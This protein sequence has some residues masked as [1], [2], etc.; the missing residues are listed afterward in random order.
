VTDLD[1]SRL[2]DLLRRRATHR[3]LDLSLAGRSMG[4]RWERAERVLVAPEARPSRGEVWMFV[5]ANGRIVAHRCRR[6][7]EPARFRGD[8]NTVDDLPVPACRLVGRVTAIQRGGRW[9]RLGAWEQLQGLGT[10]VRTW[11]R[12]LGSGLYRRMRQR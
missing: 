3:P 7:G 9:R 8:G 4:R 2:A 12:Q 5:D 1:P 11:G 10:R 6:A